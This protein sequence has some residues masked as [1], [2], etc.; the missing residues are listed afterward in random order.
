MYRFIQKHG[1]KLMAVFAAFLMVSF[2][3][4][5]MLTP[6]GAGGHNPLVGRI[7]AGGD[8]EKIYG[9]DVFIARQ[10]WQVLT[11]VTDGRGR[12]LS[13]MLGPE[14]EA[15]ITRRPVLFLLLQKEA[16]QLGVTVTQDTLQSWLQNTPGLLTADAE[17][18]EQITRAVRS[19]LLVINSAQRAASV[20]KISD[21]MVDH[22][23]AQVQQSITLN[24]V[25]FTTARYIDQAKAA[26]PTPEQVKAHFENYA[27]TIAGDASE[28]N[29]FGFGYKYPDRVKI[30]YVVV[31]K[32]DVRKSVEASKSA[33][34]WEVEARKH[35]IQNQAQFRNEAASTKPTQSFDLATPATKPTTKPYEE[36]QK[37]IKDQLIEQETER[38]M[39]TIQDRLVSTL[40][41]DWVAYRNAVGAT[42][43]ATTQASTA[44]ANAAAP[45]S[46][47]GVSYASFEYLQ[48][49]AQQ[50][51][52]NKQLGVLPTAVSIADR[53][54]TLDDLNKLPGV[55]QANLNGVPMG[56]YVMS[57]A[58]P[59]VP[60]AQRKEGGWLRVMEPTRPMVDAND[61]VY[62]VR[63][64]A[65]DPSHKPASLAEV[66]QQVRADLLTARAYE[67]AKADATKLLE[68]AR[69]A[70]LKEAAAGRPIVTAGPLTNRQGQVVPSMALTGAAS[71]RFINRA[72]KI[73]STASAA[74][75]K[76]AAPAPSTAAATTQDGG[77][78]Q[79]KPLELIELPRDGRV[80]VAELGDV[81]A[82]WTE[83]S[84]PMEQAQ[85]HR[86]LG[87]QLMQRFIPA[88]FNYDSVVARVNFVPEANAELLESGTAPQQP[89]PP[90]Q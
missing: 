88:W 36:V 53:W 60:E 67:L 14:I 42:A 31:P 10:D 82:M 33:Y 22:Q 51:Q 86:A 68:Q 4:S 65:A 64:S 9:Q 1:K 89:L 5:G 38:R 85:I 90:I 58:L 49:L 16:A 2:A 78:A 8:D 52:A 3:A 41:A 57:T 81:Q 35:Y 61:S 34:D 45:Q 19:L 15:E 83:R 26:E 55:G 59:F 79:P 50:I 74:T 56:S 32:A 76:P 37:D 30:Q 66:E 28:A 25:D 13:A 80:L 44:P 17:R 84:L 27:D 21:P 72:F 77:T 71:D 87:M 75:T 43:E 24:L 54:L 11:R 12:R 6:G 39:Q 40:G 63:L 69:Q 47:Q 23:L 48:K 7:V 18:N 73:L 29:P 70:G 46:S 62:I 20:V